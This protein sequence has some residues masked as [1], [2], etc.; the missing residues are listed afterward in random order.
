MSGWA[1]LQDADTGGERQLH[2]ICR[3]DG[4]RMEMHPHLLRKEKD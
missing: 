1:W 4:W 3:G 2:G